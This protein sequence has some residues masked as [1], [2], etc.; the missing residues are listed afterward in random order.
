V[1]TFAPDQL[2]QWTAGRWTAPP[3]AP[4]T[5]FSFDTRKLRRGDVFVALKTD[6]RDGHDFLADAQAAG[7][8]AALVANADLAVA[9][10]QLVVSS[11]LDAFQTIAREHRRAFLGRVI[12]ISGSAGKTSSKDLL[13][14]L[15]GGASC[16]VVVT[17]GNL[18]SEPVRPA[19]PYPGDV[20]ATEGNLNN[21]LGVPLTLTRIDPAVHRFAVIEAGISAPGEMA[22]LAA[23]IEPDVTII[24]LVAAAHTEELGGIGGVAREKSILPAATRPSGVAIFPSSVAEFP[25]FRELSASALVVER[26]EVLRSGE[27]AK[28]RVYFSVAQRAESTAL[29]IASSGHVREYVFRRVSDGMAQNAALAIVAA[30]WLGIAG[31]TVQARLAGWK[32]GKLRGEIRWRDGRLFYLDCYNAN[33]ASMSDALA[34]FESVAPASA[35]RLFVL[36][37]MEE[38]GADAA[39]YHQ[40]LGRSLSLRDDDQLFVIGTHA[41]DVCAGVLHQ[42]D[43]TR[44]IQTISTLAPVTA[45]L[46]EWR[47]SVFVKGSRRYQLEK[48]L[49]VQT[50]LPLPC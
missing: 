5:A 45:A 16:G 50:A 18:K 38:L 37:C 41:H 6:R 15:L 20:L 2:A 7:A 29:K 44:Q 9:L 28:N 8:S 14:L 32:P 1:P 48:I 17:E 22:P 24:T 3:L 36:G 4:L 33:P 35:P 25:A 30:R 34:T 31:E 49:E 46:P 21:H 19:H 23:M 39:A 26:V 42:G 47:G 43:F 10:P 27:P 12:G 40:A 13:S 11:T